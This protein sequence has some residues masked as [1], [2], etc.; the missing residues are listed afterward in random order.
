MES[1]PLYLHSRPVSSEKFEIKIYYN[2][3][4]INCKNPKTNRA[5][6]DKKNG[7]KENSWEIRNPDI[8]INQNKKQKKKRHKYTKQHQYASPPWIA[9]SYNHL[10]RHTLFLQFLRQLPHLLDF[11]LRVL[12]REGNVLCMTSPRD[13]LS[14]RIIEFDNRIGQCFPD[15]YESPSVFILKNERGG[16][17]NNTYSS[18]TLPPPKRP[19]PPPLHS[20]NRLHS[21]Q[22]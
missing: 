7:E 5:N 16:Y 9:P 10:H 20:P 2:N 17:M 15:Y 4:L 12:I 6:P 13:E 1:H 21:N 8:K 18:A 11:I 3:I 22:C 14:F 19:H